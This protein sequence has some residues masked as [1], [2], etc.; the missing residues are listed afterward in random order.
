MPN[1]SHIMIVAGESSGDTLG[2]N[3]MA[4]LYAKAGELKF[5][6]LGGP[7][8]VA[9]KLTSIFP[10]SDVAVMGVREIL[11]RLQ[12]LLRRIDATVAHALATK[13]DVMVL[14]DSPEFNHRVAKKVKAQRPDIPI[15]CYVAPQVWGWRRG[16]IKKMRRFF[17]AVMALWPFEPDI[18]AAHGGPPCQ[19]VGHPIITRLQD[20]V[21]LPNFLERFKSANDKKLLLVL[22]GSRVSEVRVLLPIFG[23]VIANLANDIADL[24][25]VVPVVPHVAK[26]VRPA[27]ENWPIAPI[28][29]E[30]EMEKWAAF[31]AGRAA[32]SSSGTATLE[33]G[34]AGLPSVGAYKIGMLM[35]AILMRVIRVPSVLLPNLILDR[36][37]M[38]E[39]LQGRCTAQEITP[40]IKEML[41]D[42][43]INQN[44]RTALAPLHDALSAGDTS[45]ALRAAELVL[46]YMD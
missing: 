5:T 39:F 27:V 38:P 13:P 10:M 33:L 29:V 12:L 14:I 11:P 6:G 25:P 16:R 37:V 4:A 32:L 18:F 22:P 17:D 30:D 2:A 9:Q 41:L 23:E 7:K 45:P 26:I 15:I 40:V 21:P 20:M 43:K 46:S 42:D 3:L 36:P 1:A 24:Q 19:F 34:L 28:F 35:S 31:Q 44:L 8:M